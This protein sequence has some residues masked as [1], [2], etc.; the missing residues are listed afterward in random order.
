MAGKFGEWGVLI[1]YTKREMDLTTQ[2]IR[3]VAR[4]ALYTLGL[5]LIMLLGWILWNTYQSDNLGFAS[6]TL[7]DWME[8]LLIPLVLA[9][10]G[11]W[12]AHSQKQAELEI[13]EKAREEDR[14]LAEQARWLDREIADR[15]RE[16]D[17]EIALERQQQQT[18]E[19]YLDRMK[20]LLLDR[21]LGYDAP[22]DVKRLARTWTLNV[23]RE[24]QGKRNQQ[25]VQFLQ[26]LELIRSARAA[27]NLSNANLSEVDLSGCNLKGAYLEGINLHKA[28]LQ[29]ANLDDAHLIGANLSEANLTGSLLWCAD[30]Q[31][32][33]LSKANLRAAY[34]QSALL[35]SANLENTDL[36]EANLRATHLRETNLKGAK[37]EGADLVG[38]DLTVVVN[39]RGI[40]LDGAKINNS[41][42]NQ[43][44]LPND[45]I[46]PD[47]TTYEEWKQ[48]Q[49]SEPVAN[50]LATTANSREGQ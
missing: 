38:T 33:N 35:P 28:N 20:E 43:L 1:T 5:L 37:L 12:F 27:V 3:K 23:L 11:F 29:G 50:Q 32:A 8:L 48:K 17:R 47:G 2:W 15:E 4:P 22:E 24:L 16:T 34:L 45:L 40:N 19:N 44:I 30:L 41:Q 42:L 31:R 21:G 14:K 25:I 49:E 10:A 36:R 9:V 39:W 26:E 46:M 13:A 18:L 7:W 6:K